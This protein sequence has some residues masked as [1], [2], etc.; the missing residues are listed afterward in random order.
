MIKASKLRKEAFLQRYQERL[1]KAWERMR[2]NITKELK[3][4]WKVCRGALLK[5]ADEL[6]GIREV[7]CRSMRKGS[8]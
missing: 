6:C 5:C 2:V 8:E 7:G 4:E 1:G 3:E